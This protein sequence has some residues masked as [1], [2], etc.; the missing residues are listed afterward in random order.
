MSVV[1]PTLTSDDPLLASAMLA[2][3]D[4]PISTV[5][6]SLEEDDA[7][8]RPEEGSSRPRTR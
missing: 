8:D 1:G 4:I 7:L 6:E 2:R 3:P 5:P